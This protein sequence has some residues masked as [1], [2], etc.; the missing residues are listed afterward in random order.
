MEKLNGANKI[1]PE[2]PAVI[3]AWPNDFAQAMAVSNPNIITLV[4]RQPN[5]QPEGVDFIVAISV[6]PPNGS[7]IV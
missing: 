6:V 2:M 1:R 3:V 7:V 5:H 4:G